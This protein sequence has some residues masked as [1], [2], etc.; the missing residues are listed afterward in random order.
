MFEEGR[1]KLRVACE[2]GANAVVSELWLL[3]AEAGESGKEKPKP[4]EEKPNKTI[5]Q[6]AYNQFM[7]IYESGDIERI[8]LILNEYELTR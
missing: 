2:Q 3:E 7:G 4:G 6:E 5:A 1:L 8:P